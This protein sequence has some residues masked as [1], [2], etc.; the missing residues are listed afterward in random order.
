MLPS[1]RGGVATI[2]S[3]TPASRATLTVMMTVEGYAA[4]PPG[5]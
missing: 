2:T 5:T 4:R 3:G 1:C